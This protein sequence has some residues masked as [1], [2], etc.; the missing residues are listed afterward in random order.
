MRTRTRYVLVRS[1]LLAGLT[2]TVAICAT[3]GA[4]VGKGGGVGTSEPR[5]CLGAQGAEVLATSDNGVIYKRDTQTFGCLYKD[6]VPRTLPHRVGLLDGDSPKLAGRF[7]AYLTFSDTVEFINVFD[8]H[9]DRLTVS[10]EATSDCGA[11]AVRAH[12]V[13]PSGSV[14]WIGQGPRNI[15]DE[16]GQQDAGGRL[17]VY[18]RVAGHRRSRQLASGDLIN[19]HYLKL[20]SDRASVVWRQDG[21]KERARLP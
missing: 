13:K 9:A 17:H 8:L 11:C 10:Q 16:P 12:V 4:H 7:V 21:M 14:A 5:A 18:R 3:A 6:D 20:S 1:Y 2:L 15:K 19:A